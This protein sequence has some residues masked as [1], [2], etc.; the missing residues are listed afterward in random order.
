MLCRLLISYT[1]NWGVRTVTQEHNTD[2]IVAC[3]ITDFLSSVSAQYRGR[4][5]CN[6]GN[7]YESTC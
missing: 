2:E 5:R 1:A 3:F 7:N 6:C 4:G